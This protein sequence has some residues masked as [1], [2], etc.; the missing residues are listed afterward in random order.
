MTSPIPLFGIPPKAPT[1]SFG[2][3]DD[4]SVQDSVTFAVPRHSV[5]SMQDAGKPMED[6]FAGK[7]T[8]AKKGKLLDPMIGSP[9]PYVDFTAFVSGEDVS[10][11]DKPIDM[12]TTSIGGSTPLTTAGGQVKI[13]APPRYSGKRQ[14]SVR[15]CLTQMEQ[16]IRLMKYSPLDMFLERVFGMALVL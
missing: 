3:F 13:E 15:I 11:V 1:V 16:Y 6:L 14:P 7:T 9:P 8:A 2:T 10:L 12:A 4:A 5:P